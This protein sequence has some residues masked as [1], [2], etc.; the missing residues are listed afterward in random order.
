MAPLRIVNVLL[1]SLNTKRNHF[2]CFRDTFSFDL[3]AALFTNG[4]WV[5]SPSSLEEMIQLRDIKAPLP[6]LSMTNSPDLSP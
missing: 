4:H 1:A 5:G 3:L 2:Y 6:P